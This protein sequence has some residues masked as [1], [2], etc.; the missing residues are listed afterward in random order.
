M[1]ISVYWFI[2]GLVVLS[3]VQTQ[4]YLG[5]DNVVC[6]RV[7]QLVRER[8]EEAVAVAK[9]CSVQPS[10]VIRSLCEIESLVGESVIAVN[11]ATQVGSWHCLPD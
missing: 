2:Q 6:G 1:N 8:T 7:M 9:R 10:Y 5:R 11:G 3:T 4:T